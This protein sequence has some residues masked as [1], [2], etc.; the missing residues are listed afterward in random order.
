MIF[1]ITTNKMQLFLF[2]YFQK[3]LHVSDGS[4]AHHQEYITVHSASGIQYLKLNVQL[5][6]PDD[7]WKNRLKHVEPFGNK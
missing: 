5:C 4:S 1:L 3:S 2:I 6:V 7:G